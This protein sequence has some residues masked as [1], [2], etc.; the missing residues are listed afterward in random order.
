MARDL[1]RLGGWALASLAAA[2]AVVAGVLTVVS[3]LRRRL[4]DGPREPFPRGHWPEIDLESG[5]ER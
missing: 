3:K 1:L 4:R 5:D 2:E